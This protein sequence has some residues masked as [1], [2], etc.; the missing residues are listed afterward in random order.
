MQSRYL[1]HSSVGLA[2][3]GSNT[4]IAFF[5]TGYFV[6][7]SKMPAPCFVLALGESAEL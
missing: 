3:S 1:E 5:L 6:L 7:V 2:S 4:M